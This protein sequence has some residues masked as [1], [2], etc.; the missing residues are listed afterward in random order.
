MAKWNPVYS[1]EFKR[2]KN[3]FDLCKK[4]P[5]L[6]KG[7]RQ[8]YKNHYIDF[9]QDWCITIDP[10]NSG[11]KKPSKMPFILF[12]I[13]KKYC[14]CL[15]DCVKKKENMLCE[16][17]RDMG[18][19][20]LSCA[21]SIWFFLFRSGSSIGWGSRKE[22]LVDRIGDPDSIFEK[23]RQLLLHMPF[24]LM[25]HGFKFKLHSSYMK[26]INPETGSTITGEAGDNIGRGGRSTVYFK[27]ES[28]YYEHPDM[29]EAAL[30]D[31][32]NTQVDI[33]SV[34]GT[35]NIF[36]LKRMAGEVWDTNKK[37]DKG[38][39]R[40][41]IMDWR[42]NPLKN[43]AW[44]D[45]RRAKAER[46][47]LLHL[48]AQEVDRDYKASI[49]GVV[50]KPEWVEAAVDAHKLLG[51]KMEGDISAGLDVAD[52]GPDKNALFLRQGIV[53]FYGEEWTGKDVGQTAQKT[54]SICLEKKVTSLQYDSI[55]VGAGVKAE[56]NRLRRTNKNIYEK[57]KVVGWRASASPVYPNKRVIVGDTE[58]PKNKD[59]FRNL[60]MQAWWQAR[61]R[62]EKT[63]MSVMAI[64]EKNNDFDHYKPD[65]LISISSR[66][67]KSLLAQLKNEL[68]QPRYENDAI[69]GK[70][71][72]EKK[73]D[74]TKSPDL[75]DSVVMVFCP[76]P[77]K[78]LLIV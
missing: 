12:P 5:D 13:Q 32:T 70:L 39:T 77:E 4:N 7:A 52:E 9:I 55:G 58:S 72:L 59:F 40:V 73:P 78:R 67:K 36:Y 54:M 35:N 51:I 18:I 29:I 25:P 46:E 30:G 11:T 26:L 6:Q 76:V 24:F 75:A 8:Y 38:I 63:Y 41:F 28:A 27:D 69:S 34:H 47:S 42:D 49:E 53:L 66:M 71:K 16:K 31:N 14:H 56:T 10:R 19:T 37:I 64:K 21:M 57:I 15:I 33:S 20:W 2:R 65:E 1:E 22:V 68:S 62:F 3:K 43:Q 50:I 74:G 23:L 60:R 61:I 17:S 44:Y 45:I 48:F